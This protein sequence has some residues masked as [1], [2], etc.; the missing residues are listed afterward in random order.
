MST[1][2]GAED[3]LRMTAYAFGLDPTAPN[4]AM[5]LQRL[6]EFLSQQHQHGKRALLIIDESQDLPT[7]ALEELRLLTN[8]QH[9]GKPLLQIALI[10][11][12]SLRDLVRS[13]EMEQLHQRLV[14]AWHLE[15]LDPLETVGYIQHRLMKAGWRGDPEFKPGVMQAIHTFSGGVPR[16]I[17]LVCSRLL[18]HGFIEE[19]HVI[20]IADAEFVVSEL[21][22]EELTPEN[23]L[24]VDELRSKPEEAPEYD[25][26]EHS[27]SRLHRALRRASPKRRP[28]STGLGSILGCRP[29]RLRTIV[30]SKHLRLRPISH[31]RHPR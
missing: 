6:M 17:N 20:T 9:A 25:A 19:L 27:L 29:M 16:M 12:E 8:L 4:K 26:G 14:A 3:L 30:R 21:R 5:M 24:P 18:L 10:G 28:P 7:S 15:P 1:R 11:Q 22:Q 2:L 13:R 31:C 23:F